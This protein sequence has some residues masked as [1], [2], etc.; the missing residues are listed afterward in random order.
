MKTL[1]TPPPHHW[2]LG[3]YDKK[4]QTTQGGS[5][6]DPHGEKERRTRLKSR[7]GEEKHELE[8]EPHEKGAINASSMEDNKNKKKN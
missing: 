3:G 1:P 2:S 7:A 6:K 5:H 8:H 4:T